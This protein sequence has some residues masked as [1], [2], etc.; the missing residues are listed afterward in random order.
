MKPAIRQGG[1]EPPRKKRKVGSVQGFEPG[2]EIEV[3]VLRLPVIS[4]LYAFIE[5]LEIEKTFDHD[6]LYHLNF[7]CMRAVWF[8]WVIAADLSNM[9]AV[10]TIA[11]DAGSRMVEVTMT[12]R[13]IQAVSDAVNDPD[14]HEGWWVMLEV[15]DMQIGAHDVPCMVYL[16]AAGSTNPATIGTT[17]NYEVGF[18]RSIARVRP[19]ATLIKLLRFSHNHLI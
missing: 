3:D 4:C 13:G 14:L 7:H 15:S 11:Q 18:V 6:Y 16:P 10:D 5:K 12:A 17:P 19:P 2:E 1:G 8:D 9:P